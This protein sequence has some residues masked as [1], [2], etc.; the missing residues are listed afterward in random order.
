M[1]KL[2]A[3]LLC[4]VMTFSLISS[5]A[6][7]EKDTSKIEISFKV[8]DSTLLINGKEVTVETPYIAGEG[9]TLVPLR[10][11]TEAFGAEVLWEGETKTITLNYPDVTIILQIDNKTA[12]VN[13]HTEELPVAPT[14]SASGVTMVPL[15][16]ISETFGAEVGYN[17]GAIT[18]TKSTDDFG[19]TVSTLTQKEKIGDSYYGWTMNTP[20][21]LTLADKSF[22]GRDILFTADNTEI[23]LA[24]FTLP[25]DFSPEKDFIDS[26]TELASEGALIRADM[27]KDESGNSYYIIQTKDKEVFVDVR[28]FFTEDY[29]YSLISAV[30]ADD[31]TTR[32]STLSIIDSFRIENISE[33]VYDLS[34]VKDGMRF[35]E[36]EDL[37]LSLNLPANYTVTE[38]AINELM[39]SAMEKEDIPISYA[40]LVFYSK[41]DKVNAK[42]LAESDSATRKK[43][44]NSEFVTI[45]DVTEFELNGMTVYKYTQEVKGTEKQDFSFEDIFFD[46]G[47]YVYNIGF[48]IEEGAKLDVDAIL[49]SLKAEAL[50]SEQ[51]GHI[52]RNV[53]DPGIILPVKN[54]YW[55]M[56]IPATWQASTEPTPNGAIYTHPYSNALIVITGASG[57]RLSDSKMEAN[58]KK[59]VREL[60]NDKENTIISDVKSVKFNGNKYY[61]YSYKSKGEESTVYVTAYA[62]HKEGISYAILF[63]VDEIYKTK[64]IESEFDSIIK[65]F[66]IEYKSED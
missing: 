21:N 57:E 46:L 26:K 41:T 39:F 22:D 54:S 43:Y 14:L 60:K 4:F 40:H 37:K 12:K 20:K 30:S 66:R 29:V 15:R 33:E 53:N 9:T 1:K 64:Q 63:A 59:N 42:L 23:S 25:K 17:E 55:S 28:R 2:L 32:D 51:T 8:G 27:L 50:D 11:I 48:E 36:N 47:D 52:M 5:F 31:L 18:V 61:T 44:H 6:E 56:Q 10:V 24:I 7:E 19:T 13:D 16:F 65:T 3:L 38:M 49:S 62:V 58:I 45:S 34:E 35:Y